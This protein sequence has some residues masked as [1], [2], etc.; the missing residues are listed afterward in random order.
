MFTPMAGKAGVVFTIIDG[1]TQDLSEQQV[2][3]INAEKDDSATLVTVEVKVAAA[4][5]ILMGMK[6]YNCN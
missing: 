5:K 6:C 4:A 3:L 2:T 1:V